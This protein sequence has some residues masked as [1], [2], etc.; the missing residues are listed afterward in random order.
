LAGIARAQT[1]AINGEI[2]GTVVDASGAAIIGATVG[3]V[4]VATA[5]GKA[6][7]RRRR[8]F[9]DFEFCLSVNIR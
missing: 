7:Q 6:L 1:A 2:A 3:A 5:I 9:I 8:V 4:N